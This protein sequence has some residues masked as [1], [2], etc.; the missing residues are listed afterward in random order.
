MMLRCKLSNI[1]KEFS[2]VSF[3]NPI[4]LLIYKKID[5]IEKSHFGY[6]NLREASKAKSSFFLLWA[7]AAVEVSKTSKRATCI[8][9]NKHDLVQIWA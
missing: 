9:F 3:P 7:V 8:F 2:P 4:L 6:L 5:S 1:I